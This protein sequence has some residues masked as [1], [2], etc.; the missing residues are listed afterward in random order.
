MLD[1]VL[2]VFEGHRAAF[3]LNLREFV[4]CGFQLL[5]KSLEILLCFLNLTLKFAVLCLADF[6]LLVHFVDFALFVPQQ[7]QAFFGFLHLFCEDFLLLSEQFNVFRVHFQELVDLFQLG[8]QAFG[9]LLTVV[10]RLAEFGGVAADFNGQALDFLISQNLLTS[11]LLSQAASV[12]LRLLHAV[13][14]LE[15]FPALF[16]L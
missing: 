3:S 8:L 14:F 10:Q 5:F 15:L 1:L 16:R 13:G 7:R 12:G 11:E 6:A 2:G 4:T 9:F